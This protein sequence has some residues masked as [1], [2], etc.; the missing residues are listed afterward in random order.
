MKVTNA[1]ASIAAVTQFLNM[2]IDVP[3]RLAITRKRRAFGKMLRMGLRG[4]IES[5]ETTLDPGKEVA[6]DVLPIIMHDIH[7]HYQ[8]ELKLSRDKA[9][10]RRRRAEKKEKA[11]LAIA[12]VRCSERERERERERE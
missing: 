10:R 2:P 3:R 8:P 6:V 7:F 11:R 12:N 4:R 5:G 1:Y 9:K